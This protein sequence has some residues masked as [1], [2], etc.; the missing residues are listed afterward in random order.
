MMQSSIYVLGY[1][2]LYFLVSW[3]TL[4]SLYSST[5]LALLRS[6]WKYHRLEFKEHWRRITLV[7][8][9]T[10]LAT[11]AVLAYSVFNLYLVL[12]VQGLVTEKKSYA[13]FDPFQPD[14][15]GLCYHVLWDSEKE[16]ESMGNFAAFNLTFDMSILIPVIVFVVL[17]KPHDCFVCFGKGRTE[18]R[19]SIFQLKTEEK[20]ERKLS[21]KYG[22][23]GLTASIRK[24]MVNESVKER[25]LSAE[26]LEEHLMLS[27]NY[28]RELNSLEQEVGIERGSTEK[29]DGSSIN[30]RKKSCFLSVPQSGSRESFGSSA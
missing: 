11:T 2:V 27:R 30:S 10:M 18:K 7:Y 15:H 28:E 19:Y 13:F 3:S 23:G 9:A 14:I 8:A 17:D 26:R 21:V 5:V 22:S 1:A 12:C 25:T 16:A 24:N 6:I 29:S 20:Q 4:T